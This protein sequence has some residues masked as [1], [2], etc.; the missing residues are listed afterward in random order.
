MVFSGG[1]QVGFWSVMGLKPAAIS[2]NADFLNTR[3]GISVGLGW[4]HDHYKSGVFGNVR[5]NIRIRM[6]DYFD[7]PGRGYYH[8]FGGAM[9]LSYWHADTETKQNY[10]LFES[11]FPTLQLI[12]G[13]GIGLTDKLS[14]QNEIA[15][16]PPYALRTALA[17]TIK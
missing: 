11:V 10:A 9:G 7:S 15:L 14:W 12:Y 8:Y 3:S 17:L 5:E 2:F 4:S 13:F 16:G 6:C 1:T